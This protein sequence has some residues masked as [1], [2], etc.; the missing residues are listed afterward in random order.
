MQQSLSALLIAML[1]CKPPDILVVEATYNWIYSLSWTC[2]T[3]GTQVLHNSL[4]HGNP[5]MAE[6]LR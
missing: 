4:I 3:Q 2:N 5:E 6:L 1:A